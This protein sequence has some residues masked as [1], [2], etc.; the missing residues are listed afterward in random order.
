MTP[1]AAVRLL[2]RPAYHDHGEEDLPTR[3]YRRVMGPLIA[4]GRRRAIFLAGV[5]VLLLAA[6]ALLPLELVTVKMMPFD[7]KSDFQVMIDMPEGT[8]LETT[9]RVAGA[10]ASAAL[11]D[12]AVLGDARDLHARDSRLAAIQT[13]VSP[14]EA[15]FSF[16]SRESSAWSKADSALS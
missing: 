16:V 9:A 8:A 6:V 1:W 3:L 12:D 13:P 4:S 14:V 5:A 15:Y 7:N 2:K 11:E 10:L